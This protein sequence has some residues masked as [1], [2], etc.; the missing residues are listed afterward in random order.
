MGGGKSGKKKRKRFR[1][2]KRK[3]TVLPV[4]PKVPLW[5]LRLQSTDGGK[6]EGKPVE[7]S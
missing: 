3:W 6:K 4:V 5:Q 1:L 7:V 2:P